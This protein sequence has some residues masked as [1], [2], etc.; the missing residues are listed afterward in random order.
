MEN[1]QLK[2][3]Q[4]PYPILDVISAWKGL[5]NFLLPIIYRFNIKPTKALEFGVDKGYSSFVLSKVF[6]EVVGVDKFEGDIHIGHC[7]G[8]EFYNDIK[9]L[10]SNTNVRIVRQDFEDFIS[11]NNEKYDLIHIDIVHLYEPTYKCAEWAI[12]HSNVVILHDTESFSEIKNVCR[13]IS[14]KPNINF[15]NIPY[16]HGL[17][18]LYKTNS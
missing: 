15:L 8:D 9:N 3:I 16:H 5:E 12:E 17:G 7:Q 1:E 14:S 2:P 6:K 11:N 18:I 13:D 4:W 10:F